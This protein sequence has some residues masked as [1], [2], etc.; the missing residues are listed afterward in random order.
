MSSGELACKANCLSLTVRPHLRPPR[1]CLPLPLPLVSAAQPRKINEL[2]PAQKPC[3][4]NPR[5]KLRSKPA[6]HRPP[7]PGKGAGCVWFR[8]DVVLLHLFGSLAA[9]GWL[10][11]D[12]MLVH[13][14]RILVGFGLRGRCSLFFAGLR[15][16]ACAHRCAVHR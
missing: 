5:V 14:F 1:L 3:I 13:L 6:Q 4:K 7:K 12:V 9:S 8:V 16:T 11:A 10:R 2:R 15:L